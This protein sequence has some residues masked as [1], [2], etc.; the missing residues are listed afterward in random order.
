MPIGT[1]LAMRFTPPARR[2]QS[3]IRIA[4]ASQR[5]ALCLGVAT[6][7][8]SI[9]RTD[10]PGAVMTVR[11]GD[12]CQQN[13]D[14]SGTRSVAKS[15]DV[16]PSGAYRNPANSSEQFVDELTSR[17]TVLADARRATPAQDYA[18]SLEDAWDIVKSWILRSAQYADRRNGSSLV[19]WPEVTNSPPPCRD[20]LEPPPEPRGFV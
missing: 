13:E 19:P 6:C 9:G 16:M 7:A 17:V 18:R 11:F 14:A 10:L 8:P 3:K 12:E 15:L 4:N 20:Q 2:F 5:R 1:K